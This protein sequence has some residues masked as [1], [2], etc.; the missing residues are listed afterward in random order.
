MACRHDNDRTILDVNVKP[1]HDGTF[2]LVIWDENVTI[3]VAVTSTSSPSETLE[4]SG[5]AILVFSGMD[6]DAFDIW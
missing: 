3:H 1:D 4:V 2:A 6:F 5:P